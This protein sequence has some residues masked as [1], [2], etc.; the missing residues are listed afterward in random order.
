M[1]TLPPR[2]KYDL[3]LFFLACDRP[4]IGIQLASRR[5]GCGT[6][7]TKRTLMTPPLRVSSRWKTPNDGVRSQETMRSQC[8]MRSRCRDDRTNAARTQ[9]L[10]TDLPSQ[11]PG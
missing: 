9:K 10:R 2:L 7:V 3:R 8:L 5:D 11:S 1:R 6:V 4:S